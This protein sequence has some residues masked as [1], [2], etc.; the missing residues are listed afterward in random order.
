MHLKDNHLNNMEIL[1]ERFEGVLAVFLIFGVFP[2]VF[3][4]FIYKL[5]TKKMETIVKLTELDGKVNLIMLKTLI[6]GSGSHKKDYKIGLIWLAIGLPFIFMA[7]NNS[8]GNFHVLTL[9]PLFIGFA[10]LIS[11]KLRLREAEQN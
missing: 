6:D 3:I 1:M 5:K 9:I 11:G 2:T 4:V 7:F 10:Y 8:F